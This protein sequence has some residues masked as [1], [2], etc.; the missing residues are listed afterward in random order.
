MPIYQRALSPQTMLRGQATGLLGMGQPARLSDRPD[1]PQMN[2]GSVDFGAGAAEQQRQNEAQQQA[3]GGLM[4]LATLSTLAYG[5]YT[6]DKT[7]ASDWSSG[8]PFNK[9]GPLLS[10]QNDDPFSYF[11]D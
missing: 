11:E 4:D 10:Y 6:G 8:Y 2:V 5:A 7:A 1:I 3:L 9:Q